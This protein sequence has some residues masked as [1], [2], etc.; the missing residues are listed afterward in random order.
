MIDGMGVEEMLWLCY[1]K[2]REK[3]GG[4]HPFFFFAEILWNNT[5]WEWQALEQKNNFLRKTAKLLCMLDSANHVIWIGI[6]DSGKSIPFLD[7]LEP[8]KICMTTSSS[9]PTSAISAA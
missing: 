2:E 9:T 3:L 5:H 6:E 1:V 7:I 4:N 8:D